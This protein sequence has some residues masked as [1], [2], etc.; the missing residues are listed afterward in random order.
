MTVNGQVGKSAGFFVQLRRGSLDKNWHPVFGLFRL[1][2]QQ[3]LK[4]RLTGC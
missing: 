4:L 2:M 1:I 3:G